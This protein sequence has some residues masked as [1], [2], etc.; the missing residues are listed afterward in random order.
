MKEIE[1]ESSLKLTSMGN[2][3]SLESN[4]TKGVGT[5]GDDLVVPKVAK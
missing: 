4:G 1:L 5:L 2:T 3:K